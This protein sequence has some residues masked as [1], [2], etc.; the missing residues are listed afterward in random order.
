M[1]YTLPQ[2]QPQKL[3]QTHPHSITHSELAKEQDC[4]TIKSSSRFQN[5]SATTPGSIVTLSLVILY[6]LISQV[7]YLFSVSRD[8]QFEFYKF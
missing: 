3:K 8:Y 5:W 6:N 1:G 2:P 7:F 4:A